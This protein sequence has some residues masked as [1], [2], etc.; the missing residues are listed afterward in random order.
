M[1]ARRRAVLAG[2]TILTA[3]AVIV[4]AAGAA[5][6]W[7][8]NVRTADSYAGRREGRV[9]FAIVVPGGRLYGR[10]V[11]AHYRSA[12]VVKAM[13]LAAYLSSR[14]VRGRRLRHRDRA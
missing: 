8:D 13:L 3:L 1:T 12:S 6:S 5:P 10:H 9:A 14:A 4:P 11:H 2:A 7:P